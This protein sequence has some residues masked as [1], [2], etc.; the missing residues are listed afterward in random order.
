MFA[1]SCVANSNDSV[2]SGLTV[3]TNKLIILDPVLFI[4]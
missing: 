2:I 3:I 4:N 1:L